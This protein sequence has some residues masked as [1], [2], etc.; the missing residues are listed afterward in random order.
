[1]RIAILKNSLFQVVTTSLLLHQNSTPYEMGSSSEQVLGY[2]VHC[3]RA[4]VGAGKPVSVYVAPL[5]AVASR[6]P[7]QDCVLVR[8]VLVVVWI[9]LVLIPVSD[10]GFRLSLGHRTA[11]MLRFADCRYRAYAP[12]SFL[13]FFLSFFFFFF[14]FFFFGGGGWGWG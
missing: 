7:V 2:E 1:M 4:V 6:Q 3:H 12:F 8:L 14:F 13:F 9:E 10:N 5:S 11:D